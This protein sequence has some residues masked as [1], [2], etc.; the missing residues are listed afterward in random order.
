MSNYPKPDGPTLRAI[1]EKAARIQF[2]DERVIKEIKAGKLVM[3]FYSTRGQEIIPAAISVSLT[4][5][6]YVNTIYRGGHDQIAKGFPLADY[7]AEIA[8]RVTGA[9]K[10]K[11][12]PMHLTY[13]AKGIMVT[14]G[15]VGSTA[16]IANGLAWAAKLEGKGRVTIAN[17]GD[18]AANIGA[19]HEAMEGIRVDG[20]DPDEMY[21]V[22]RWA[23]D[24]AR[25]GEGPTFIEA[26]TFRFNGHLI[27]EAG[28][29][30]DKELYAASQTRDPMPILRRRLV[31]EGIVA[32][33]ELDALDASIRAEIDAAVRTAY[34][35]DYPDPSELKVD[36]LV[37]AI[38]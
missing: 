18:G 10:G 6:D 12:G 32:A 37:D 35:A 14:T 8:G 19:V 30:M 24:R 11:G 13:P 22:A 29:Y 4:D 20:N 36:V 38:A 17:F 5:D 26:T 33:G 15:I 21:G 1:Y 7:W 27:G 3:P 28:G 31:E 25:A 9:C 34:A 23:I 2:N 16:P